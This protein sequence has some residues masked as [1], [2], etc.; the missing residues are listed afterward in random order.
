MDSGAGG[1]V[2]LKEALLRCRFGEAVY[3][4][5]NGNAPYG[6]RGKRDLMSLAVSGVE[7]GRA[8]CRERV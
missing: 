5:D 3:F 1:L 6:N 8:S 2:V 7:I 4:G